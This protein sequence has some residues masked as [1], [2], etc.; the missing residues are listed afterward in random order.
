MAKWI[1]E[2]VERFPVVG[3]DSLDLP[4]NSQLLPIEAQGSVKAIVGNYCSAPPVSIGYIDVE[5]DQ[6]VIQTNAE[7]IE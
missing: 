7:F 1:Y 4:C 6:T 5:L 2:E 3:L